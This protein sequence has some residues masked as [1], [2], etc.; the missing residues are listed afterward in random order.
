MGSE[1]ECVLCAGCVVLCCASCALS[2][3]TPTLLC[4]AFLL[5]HPEAIVRSSLC[6][7]YYPPEMVNARSNT[8]ATL[9]AVTYLRG[10]Y[11]SSLLLIIGPTFLCITALRYV[12]TMV[13]LFFR[14]FFLPVML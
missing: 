12:S 4:T 13:S 3:P 8:A 14:P 10:D 11:L 7:S 2:A 6:G 5:Y 9:R 1:G